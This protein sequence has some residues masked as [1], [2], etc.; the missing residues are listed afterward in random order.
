M[1]QQDSR[2]GYRVIYQLLVVGYAFIVALA[3]MLTDSVWVGVAFLSLQCLCAVFC[4][5]AFS[6]TAR[7]E[8]GWLKRFRRQMLNFLLTTGL[9]TAGTIAALLASLVTP[10]PAHH[11]MLVFLFALAFALFLAG[12]CGAARALLGTVPAQALALAVG[13]LMVSTPYYINPFIR[14]SSGALRMRVVQA[15][16]NINP[17]LVGAAGILKFDWLRHSDLY[18][19]CLIGG[20]Q[21]PFYYPGALKTGITLGVIGIILIALS[22]FGKVVKSEETG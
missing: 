11:V 4:V 5:P 10:V 20:W 22:S 9:L 1:T 2:Q 7:G 16:V 12:I 3:V 21:F 19:T 8:Q 14:A 15:A 18:Q 17:L 13:L 6:T